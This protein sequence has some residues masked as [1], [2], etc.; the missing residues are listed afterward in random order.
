MIKNILSYTIAALLL[1]SL[2]PQQVHADIFSDAWKTVTSSANKLRR[3]LEKE[4]KNAAKSVKTVA[5]QTARQTVDIANQAAKEIDKTIKLLQS[6]LGTGEALCRTAMQPFAKAGA[7]ADKRTNQLLEAF[8]RPPGFS[9]GYLNIKDHGLS[10]KIGPILK[11]LNN[12]ECRANMAEGFNCQ[13]FGYLGGLLS[14]IKKGKD[15]T[16]RLAQYIAKYSDSLPCAPMYAVPGISTGMTCAVLRG[17][18]EEAKPGLECSSQIFK[19]A[20]KNASLPGGKFTQ[21]NANKICDAT[22]KKAFNYV[23]SAVM[24]N[25][26]EGLKADVLLDYANT[27]NSALG[28]IEKG[29]KNA[30]YLSSLCKVGISSGETK[31]EQ[32]DSSVLSYIPKNAAAGQ[33]LMT[34]EVNPKCMTVIGKHSNDGGG[35]G[36]GVWDCAGNLSQRWT[37]VAKT[38]RIYSD[39]GTTKTVNVEKVESVKT[40][41]FGQTTKKRVKKPVTVRNLKNGCL[42]APSAAQAKKGVPWKTWKCYDNP[43]QKF[44]LI[45]GGKIYNK[46]TNMCANVRGGLKNMKN[47]T[48]IISWPCENV[49]NEKWVV[50]DQSAGVVTANMGA[51]RL[52]Y[53]NPQKPQCL[54]M[55]KHGNTTMWPC[56]KG[57][58]DM[59][60][61][62]HHKRG[63]DDR[64]QIYDD[65]HGDC[66]TMP[67]KGS[68][69]WHTKCGGKYARFQ[70]F[71]FLPDG[72]IKNT[73]GYNTCISVKGGNDNWGGGHR[74]VVAWPC[75]DLK[76]QKWHWFPR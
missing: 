36:V 63:T 55:N 1:V 25:V 38:G 42:N 34:S 76:H 11:K 75:E 23:A 41:P 61:S 50:I 74:E 32:F 27:L 51:H 66:L 10:K 43:H 21:H 39:Y 17:L 35:Y 2:V 14:D 5:V 44:E 53:S 54:T 56:D 24:G 8:P 67:G 46:H 45:E 19:D 29:H 62:I 20:I 65:R 73:G 47:R 49:A 4:A 16:K 37:Y 30:E 69:L 68:L 72:L 3:N 40:G 6:Y 31:L 26:T 22:G 9:M 12:F 58:S 18:Y 48:T 7:K 13:I 28:S 52:I 59:F 15:G 64:G 33:M 71:Q 57:D 70:E 60:W